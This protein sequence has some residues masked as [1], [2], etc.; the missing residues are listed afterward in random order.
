MPRR[1][2]L[3]KP[4]TRV[5]EL[6]LRGRQGREREVSA[7]D[8]P[9]AVEQHQAFGGHGSSVPADRRRAARP[10]P[11]A[12]RPA[13][14][15]R[16][17][18]RAAQRST[19]RP[20]P[21]SEQDA[22]QDERHRSAGV[23]PR[24]EV[25]VVADGLDIVRD[26]AGRLRRRRSRSRPGE[27]GFGG[28]AASPPRYPFEAAA[29]G[30][31]ET[32]A[33]AADGAAA[34]SA[35]PLGASAMADAPGASGAGALDA[36]PSAGADDGRRHGRDA[37]D[38]S[39]AADRAAGRRAAAPVRI[40]GTVATSRPARPSVVRPTASGRLKP[41]RADPKAATSRRQPLGRSRAASSGV[42]A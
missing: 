15:Q 21:A 13:R 1:T 22:G 39:C 9:V 28:G 36:R 35:G 5:D 30:A 3:Q 32:A 42:R 18:R 19:N 6:A 34:A 10:D 20:R 26:A 27:P 31:G 40:D 23:R 33:A 4:K 24:R 41:S 29:A 38:E 14:D 12:A 11:A 17:V 16:A 2:M 7:V 37:S 25:V 8:E